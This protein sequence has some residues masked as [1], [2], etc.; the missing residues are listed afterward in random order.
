[1]RR[2]GVT[3][4]QDDR[5]DTRLNLLDAERMREYTAPRRSSSVHM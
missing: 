3:V 1:M 4:M 5:V 2:R